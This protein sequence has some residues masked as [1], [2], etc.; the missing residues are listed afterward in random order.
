MAIIYLGPKGFRS[1]GPGA[2]AP[3][4][5]DLLKIYFKVA[6]QGEKCPSE[7]GSRTAGLAF[8]SLTFKLLY[9]PAEVE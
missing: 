1:V 5:F 2:P 7:E 6:S 8:W 4:P 3:W 9:R